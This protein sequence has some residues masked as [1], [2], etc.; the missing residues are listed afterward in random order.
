MKTLFPRLMKGIAL[1][2][3]LAGCGRDEPPEIPEFRI[4]AKVALVDSTVPEVVPDP[5]ASAVPTPTPMPKA[6]P[7]K[8]P[9]PAAKTKAPETAPPTP[10]PEPV[11]GPSIVGTWQVTEMSHR[12]QSHPMPAGMQ[13]T[14]TFGQ[15][16]SLTMS[17][18]GGQMPQAITQQGTYTLSGNQLTVTMQ[19]QTKTG[20]CTFEGNDKLTLEVDEAKM[21]M[22]RM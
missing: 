6:E 21:V 20:A 17:T 15:D 3:A 11:A 7:T 4:P 19:N 14:F 12:G 5:S 16:G 18:S 10:T 1:A 2:I 9:S 8:G 22:A 13:M